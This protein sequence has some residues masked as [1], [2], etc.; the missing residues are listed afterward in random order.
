MI[1]EFALPCIVDTKNINSTFTKKKFVPKE[2]IP[3]IKRISTQRKGV[4]QTLKYLAMLR[5]EE[6]PPYN[7]IDEVKTYADGVIELVPTSNCYQ[8]L[9]IV[10]TT[11]SKRTTQLPKTG[12]GHQS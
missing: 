1:Y 11:F 7:L 12:N 2:F 8:T 5:L 3:R 10:R 9:M 4:K 6:V